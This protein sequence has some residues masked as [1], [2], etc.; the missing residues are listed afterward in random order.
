MLITQDT[1]KKTLNLELGGDLERGGGGDD[2]V[3]IEELEEKVSAKGGRTHCGR[4]HE[5]I[6]KIE[7]RSQ[8]R[9]SASYFHSFP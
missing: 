3:G 4:P 7:R 5:A 2:V 6:L 9:S 8:H 1:K